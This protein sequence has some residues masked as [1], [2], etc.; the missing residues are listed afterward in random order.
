M[1]LK[2][3]C[4]SC[5]S[6]K[7]EVIQTDVVITS[8]IL[9]IDEEGC[10]EFDLTDSDGGNVDRFQCQ[11]CGYVLKDESGEPITTNEDVVEWVKKQD[12]KSR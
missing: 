12:N 2:F 8:E 3:K 7:L 4:P 9:D 6:E 1:S 11:K 10:F 5:G